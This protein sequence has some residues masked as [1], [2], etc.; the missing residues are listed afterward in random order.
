[1]GWGRSLVGASF[2]IAVAASAGVV[3]ADALTDQA[4]RLLEQRQARQAYELLLPQESARAGDPEFDYLLGIAATDAGQPERAVFAL[5]RVLAVQPANH[6]ARAEIARAYLALGEREAAR[7]E[8]ETVRRQP[9]PAEAKQSIE[10]LL[11]A[12]AVPETTRISGYIELGLGYDSNVNSATADSQIALPGLGIIGTLDPAFTRQSDSFTSL[13]GGVSASHKFSP[14][15]AMT[16]G[17]AAAAKL[18]HDHSQFDTLSLDANLGG[19]YSFG[20]EALLLGAQ[21]Q[22]FEL[23]SERYRETRGLIAQWQ[24]SYDDRSQATLYAQLSDLEYPTQRIRDAVRQVLGVAYAR[25][26]S[27]RYTPVLFV[28]AYGGREREEADGVPH[29]G[30][31]LVGARVGGQGRLAARWTLFGNL[32]LEQRRYGGAEPLFSATRKDTQADLSAGVSYAIGSRTT[33]VT[34]LSYTD[35]DSNIPI[36]DF[37]RG[38]A[39]AALRVNF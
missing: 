1:M 24:H 29:L 3:L 36:N 37:A 38:V 33:L 14:R 21:L 5:E 13:A 12:I 23:D 31:K 20:D 11:S 6:L 25:A 30:H 18:N 7:R 16:G 10:R 28:S 35:N 22:N 15:W 27:G 8:L 4:R 34:Q 9:V 26:F 17:L 32:A 2:G 39:S 19:R